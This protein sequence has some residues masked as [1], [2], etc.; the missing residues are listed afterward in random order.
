MVGDHYCDDLQEKNRFVCNYGNQLHDT[1]GI[2]L[3]SSIVTYVLFGI[4]VVISVLMLWK[5]GVKRKIFGLTFF[6]V[7][8]M[9][10][11]A[12]LFIV[13]TALLQKVETIA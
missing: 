12:L 7:A 11:D 3:M 1:E 10:L 5:S 6:L 2:R 4:L 9:L 13:C 8:V